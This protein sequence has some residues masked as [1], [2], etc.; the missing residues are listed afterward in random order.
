M[1][2]YYQKEIRGTRVL[3]DLEE[4]LEFQKEHRVEVIFEADLQY[5]CYIDGEGWGSGLTTLG[6]I[7]Y[8]IRK[9][10]KNNE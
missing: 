8:G 10:K 2:D 6:A 9:F 1:I 3:F 5:M 4:I 7:V